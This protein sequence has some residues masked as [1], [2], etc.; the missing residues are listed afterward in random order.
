MSKANLVVW[1]KNVYY[2]NF[3]FIFYNEIVNEL[4]LYLI[5]I[6]S[7]SFWI[8]VV[9]VFVYDHKNYIRIRVSQSVYF[10]FSFDE[11]KNT[12]QYVNRTVR[13]SRQTVL[14]IISTH[15]YTPP[16]Q[17][18]CHQ[19]LETNIEILNMDGTMGR[20]W[21]IPLVDWSKFK[22]TQHEEFVCIYS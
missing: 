16:T 9:Q 17:S 18:A 5:N 6:F 13:K 8:S 7:G 3:L 14:F 4:L 1:F 20:G 2:S 15:Y 22:K 10:L 11:R 12:R 21:L 19:I